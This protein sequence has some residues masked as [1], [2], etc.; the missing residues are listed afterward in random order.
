VVGGLGGPILVG[1]LGGPILVGWPSRPPLTLLTSSD[2][3]ERVPRSFRRFLPQSGMFARWRSPTRSE[4]PAIDTV[5]R[6]EGKP[7][8]PV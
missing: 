2:V 4:V 3:V 5:P 8:F 6:I 1:G 7:P